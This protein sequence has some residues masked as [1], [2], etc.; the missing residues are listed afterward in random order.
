MV[1][2]ARRQFV[3]TLAAACVAPA[4]PAGEFT[5]PRY[6]GCRVEADGRHLASIFDDSGCIL[7]DVPLPGRGHGFA[8]QPGTGRVVVFA[9]RPGG[10]ALILDPSTGTVAGR[11]AATDGRHFYGHGTFSRDGA[12]LHTSES[13][14]EDGAGV[15]GVWDAKRAWQRICEWSSG[16]V[17]PH[18]IRAFGH[19]RMLAV[20]NGGIRTHPDTGRAKLN[21]ET[22]SSSL[23]ILDTADGRM[24]QTASLNARH[25]R[26]SIRH[27]D[28]D[29]DARIV[30]A[31][32]HEGHRLQRVPLIAFA[33]NA[34]LVPAYAPEDVGRGMRRYT[35][36]A[37]FDASG[38]Y[39]AITHPHDGIVSVW[40]A[41]SARLLSVAELADTCGV[42]P[43]TDAGSFIATGA[44]GQI[45]R[46]D[47]RSG[48]ST[49]LSRSD[50]T[51][52]DNH[53]VALPGVA[54]ARMPGIHT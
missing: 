9:R 42:A 21:L 41:R 51:H 32:Q 52:W 14:F 12:L 44:H 31:M 30:V 13:R 34:S 6:V 5:G 1:S 49:L 43:G 48:E 19:G 24:V 17:G 37:S 11:L 3:T 28:I 29:R 46:I 33:R 15:I 7:H 2:I 8:V 53:L 10:W 40:S 22:M 50:G 26:L 47:A 27:L 35:G 39:A 25:R 54:R 36:S 45:M 18:E 4:L 16:G 23:A 38:R 20:A